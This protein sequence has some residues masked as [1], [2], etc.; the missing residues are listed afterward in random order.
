MESYVILVIGLAFVIGGFVKYNFG[1]LA[2]GIILLIY[3]AV[4]RAKK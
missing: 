1:A 3:F 2:F 4:A